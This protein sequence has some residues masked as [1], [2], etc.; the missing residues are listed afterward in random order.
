M[1]GYNDGQKSHEISTNKLADKDKDIG[2]II[3][4]DLEDDENNNQTNSSLKD[5][6]IHSNIGKSTVQ[7]STD[8]HFVD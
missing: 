8:I 4:D 1:E 5:K 2:T 7:K 6:F 3:I